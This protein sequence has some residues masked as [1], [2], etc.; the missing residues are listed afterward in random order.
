MND[1][2]AFLA[3]LFG[4]TPVRQWVLSLP[5]PLRY[6]LAYDSVVLGEVV[7]AF[8]QAVSQYLRWKAKD[9]LGLRS[10][11]HAYP[12]AVTAIQRASSDASLNIHFHS[13]F[14]DGVFVQ[15]DTFEPVLFHE[16]PPPTDEEVAG[17]AIETSRRVRV[18]LMRHN[19]W[20]DDHEEDPGEQPVPDA[21]AD[22]YGASI[23]GVLCGGPRRGQRVVRFFGE[24]ARR[25][26]DGA[27]PR[28]SGD[29]FNLHARQA[30][31]AGDRAAV[32]ILSSYYDLLERFEP[33]VRSARLPRRMCDFPRLYLHVVDFTE[34]GVHMRPLGRGIWSLLSSSAILT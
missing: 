2:A 22:L 19:L 30:T 31:I 25:S 11:S 16:L 10:V 17:V 21:L 28:P 20:K 15:E 23:R 27:V 13:L 33:R 9:V 1:G 5:K 26:S 7:T 34:E 24:A 29:A 6:V 14:T 8:V 32:E 4:D 3:D 12:G 18:I